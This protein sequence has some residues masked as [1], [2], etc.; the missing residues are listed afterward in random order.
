MAKS[1][2]KFSITHPIDHHK[3]FGCL[4]LGGLTVDWRISR[5]HPEEDLYTFSSIVTWYTS[6]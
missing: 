4:L 3:M 2:A 6:M 1:N 5:V